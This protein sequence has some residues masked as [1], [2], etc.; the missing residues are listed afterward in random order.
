[1]ILM[2][3]GCRKYRTS[4]CPSNLGPVICVFPAILI[5][6]RLF[7]SITSPSFIGRLSVCV[8]SARNSLI[9]VVL[10]LSALS[11]YASVFLLILFQE[12]LSAIRLT[13]NTPSMI[14]NIEIDS[15]NTGPSINPKSFRKFTIYSA[16]RASSGRNSINP[17]AK[18]IAPSMLGGNFRIS[19]KSFTDGIS[20]IIP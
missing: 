13:I 12:I 15:I 3:L 2:I 5:I 16:L 18:E 11:K 8:P 6:P 17:D 10:T 7:S 1:M 9:N 19:R 4:N 14:L 20:Y